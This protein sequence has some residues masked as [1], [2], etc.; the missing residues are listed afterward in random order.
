MG[1]TASTAKKIKPLSAE[2][3][4]KVLQQQISQLQ[5]EL[6][7]DKQQI[8]QL[9]KQL[10]NV[11]LHC[12]TQN[13]DVCRQNDCL[14]SKVSELEAQLLSNPRHE[15]SSDGTRAKCCAGIVSGKNRRCEQYLRDVFNR[16]KDASGGLSGQSMVHA[17]Q[18]VDAPNIP[19]SDADIADLMK[20]FDGNCNRCLEFGEFQQVANDAAAP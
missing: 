17:L 6:Q 8:S 7:S 1:A 14:R 12:Q 19:A 4:V 16:Y 11:E 9:Q 5:N 20:Q 3:Q 2:D 15:F 10:V 13:A 18:N